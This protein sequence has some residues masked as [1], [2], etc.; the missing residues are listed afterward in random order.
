MR[1]VEWTEPAL[2]DFET[3]LNDL[4][5]RDPRVAD[6]AE[7]DIRAIVSRLVDHPRYGHKGRWPELLEWSATRWRKIIVYREL[8]NGLRVIAL[9]DARQDLSA[10]D[11]SEI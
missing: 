10:I 6:R 5:E 11:L 9:L 7:Q 1:I 3:F 4:D 2:E 8:P